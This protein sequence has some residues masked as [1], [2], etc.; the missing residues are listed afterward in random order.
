MEINVIQVV[1]ICVY[2]AFYTYEGM[3]LQIMLYGG[4]TV[5]GGFVTGLIMGNPVLGL[6]I[7]ATLQLMSLGIG[8][9]GGASVPDYH[10]G[11]VIG[12]IV[13]VSTGRDLES[14]LAIALPVSLIMIQLDVLV[15]MA[16][17]FFLHQSQKASEKLQM[18]KAYTWIICGQIPWALKGILP[19]LLVFIV[20]VNNIDSLLNLFP[21]WLMGTFK[22]AGG[23]LPAVGIGILLKYMNAKSYFEYL[24]VGF[25]MI[26]YLQ[27][28]MLGI[29]LFGLAIAIITFKNQT[30]NENKTVV[31]TTGGAMDDEL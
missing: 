25:A 27:I 7:G 26:S 5:I 18:K 21:T 20:G 19:I 29:A 10:T 2:M 15:R 14:A 28:P 3:N 17:T 16:T 22:V 12:T 30:K 1:L 9:Y 8:A 23:L 11:A 24:L 4:T 6:T 13:A 31:A